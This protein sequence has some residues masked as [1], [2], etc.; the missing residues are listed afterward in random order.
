MRLT[1]LGV[2]PGLCNPS[3]SVGAFSLKQIDLQTEGLRGRWNRTETSRTL[4][5]KGSVR[6]CGD[7]GSLPWRMVDGSGAGVDHVNVWLMTS[8]QATAR[9]QRCG[10]MRTT[11]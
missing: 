7:T 8:M 4:D 2:H 10:R 1:A 3:L 6:S 5:A 11:L 9:L